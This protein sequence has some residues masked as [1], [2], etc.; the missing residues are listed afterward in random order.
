LSP[1]P[2]GQYTVRYRR[3]FEESGFLTDSE[4]VNFVVVTDPHAAAAVPTLS[5]SMYAFLAVIV[6]MAAFYVTRRRG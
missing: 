5:L 3:F 1:L 2:V 4:D 6:L